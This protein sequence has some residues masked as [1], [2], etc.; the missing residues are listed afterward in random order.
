M[1]CYFSFLF[2]LSAFFGYEVCGILVHQPGIEPK[3]PAVEARCL[4]HWTVWEVPIMLW[5]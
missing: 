3:T 2:L 1:L 4:N 5:I